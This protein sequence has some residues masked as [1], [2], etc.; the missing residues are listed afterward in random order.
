VEA[1]DPAGR[2]AVERPR[3]RQQDL[4]PVIAAEIELRLLLGATRKL[5]SGA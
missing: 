4:Q 1:L 3:A 5:R 2:A